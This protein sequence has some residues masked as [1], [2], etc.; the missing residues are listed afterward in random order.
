M[1]TVYGMTDDVPWDEVGYII[2]SQYRVTVLDRLVRG[3]ATPSQIAADSNSTIAHVSRALK[4]LRN[5]SLVKL[6]VSEQRKKGRVY[7]ITGDAESV[8]RIIEAQEMA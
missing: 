7:G 6:L 1:S 2:S 3:P 5:R 8:W 4:E